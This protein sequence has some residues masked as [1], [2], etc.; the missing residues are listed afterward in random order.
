M[1]IMN[2]DKLIGMVTMRNILEWL[3]QQMQEENIYLKKYI[4]GG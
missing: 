4:Q 2:G 3:T 1:V